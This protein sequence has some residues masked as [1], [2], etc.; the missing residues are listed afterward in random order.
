MIFGDGFDGHIVA[1]DFP[2][3][4][5]VRPIRAAD[6]SPSLVIRDESDAIGSRAHVRRCTTGLNPLVKLRVGGADVSS[7][8]YL[9]RSRLQ[10]LLQYCQLFCRNHRL[11]M[12]ALIC[13]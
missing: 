3:R 9:R 5:I 13:R 10:I 8:G 1:E 6:R 7:W 11:R 2:Y 4:I 12:G